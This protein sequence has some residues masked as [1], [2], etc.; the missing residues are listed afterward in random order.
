L[1]LAALAVPLVCSVHSIVGLDF[2]AS[3]MPGW[4][5][6]IFPP[7]FVVGAMYSGFAMVILL[8]TFIRWG[9]GLERF[10]TALHYQSMAV[11]VL[12]SSL[13]MG[14]SYATE[15]FTAWY[16]GKA[17][18]RGVIAYE[19]AGP[20]GWMFWLLLLFNVALPQVLWWPPARRSRAVLCLVS[21]GI[22]IGMWFERI[23]IIW[24]TLGYTHLPSM[25]HL[26]YPTL[27]DWT[28]LFGPLGVFAFGFLIFARILPIM[29]MY[30]V[31]ELAQDRRGRS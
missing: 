2:A 17:L 8:A 3:L 28:F 30:E 7:Y 20:Y 15:W 1:T 5:E 27:T 26:F 31:R 21:V 4:Q 16:G 12:V 24:N 10:I 29:S 22:L 13:V 6:P 25:R 23:L 14:A 18:D 19:F 9:L 11:I